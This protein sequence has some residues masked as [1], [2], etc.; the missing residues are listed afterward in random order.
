MSKFNGHKFTHPSQTWRPSLHR[1]WALAILLTFALSIPLSQSGATEERHVVVVRQQE[2]KN[3]KRLIRGIK[4]EFR[5]SNQTAALDV[6]TVSGLS[7]NS[8]ELLDSLRA[9]HPTVIVPI[10]SHITQIVS[11]SI[12][13]VSIVFGAVLQPVSSGFVKQNDR[14]GGRVTG[15]SLDISPALQFKYFKQIYPNLRKLGIIYSDETASMIPH[16]E[17]VAKA[18]GIELHTLK[19]RKLSGG[20]T[21]REVNKALDSLLP[22]VD[23]LWSL[24]DP[25]VFSPISTKLVIKRTL[26]KKIPFMGFSS[27]IV[28]SGALFALDFDYKDIGRQV[29]E[30]SDQILAGAD[31]GKLPV[32]TPD[33]V[34]FHYNE[35]TSTRIAIA[36]PEELRAVAK[37]VFK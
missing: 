2:D 36:I 34:W 26:Q 5:R 13:D 23:G 15:A 1:L 20:R 24:A 6:I 27:T 37:E 18:N 30:L 16:A 28:A 25:S 4:S 3:S 21:G 22:I 35:K 33:I 11:D 12:T 14:P 32:T 7:G 10:G 19:I 31:P 9:L 17:I 29:G 8:Q